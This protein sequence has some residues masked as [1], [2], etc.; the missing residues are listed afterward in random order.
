M[1]PWVALQSD[2]NLCNRSG[3]PSSPQMRSQRVASTAIMQMH[4]LLDRRHDDGRPRLAPCCMHSTASAAVPRPPQSRHRLCCHPPPPG[5]KLTLFST[6]GSW[7]WW[8][9]CSRQS[10]QGRAK[11]PTRTHKD[12][13]STPTPRRGAQPKPLHLCQL[14]RRFKHSPNTTM[15][16][17]R[18][19]VATLG[20]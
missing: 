7:W 19:R 18:P 16:L 10:G 17:K 14:S 5:S 12:T 13:L 3:A 11:P 15:S 2:I 9:R 20:T 4:R 8:W 6:M 1:R